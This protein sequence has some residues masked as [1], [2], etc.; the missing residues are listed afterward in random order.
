MGMGAEYIVLRYAC[1]HGMSKSSSTYRSRR[2]SKPDYQTLAQVRYL[3]R[4]FMA[5]SHDAARAAGLTVQQHQALLAIHGFPGLRRV[6]VGELAER[7]NVR[8]HSVVGLLDRLAAKSLVLRRR[9]SLD[10]RRVHIELTA[11]GRALLATLSLAHSKELRRLAPLL[12]G[13]LGHLPGDSN[14]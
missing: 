3:L 7:L 12:V 4:K 6:M 1:P 5:F 2:L 9:N 11:K 14:R 8:H 10:R 13:L